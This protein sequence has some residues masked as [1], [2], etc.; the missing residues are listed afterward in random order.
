VL[1]ENK[2]A[3]EK[4]VSEHYSHNMSVIIIVYYNANITYYFDAF[5]NRCRENDETVFFFILI[6]R[7][8]VVQ[9]MT[10]SICGLVI[11]RLPVKKKKKIPQLS[12][13]L[14]FY[15]FI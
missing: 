6:I 2:C 1:Y 7:C 15:I 11:L 3:V 4:T 13:K 10:L 5:A 14:Y 12:M 8:N 9:M